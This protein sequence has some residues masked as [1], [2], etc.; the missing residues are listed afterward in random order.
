M[1]R[2]RTGER[3]AEL[4]WHVLA[5][6]L[7]LTGIG[8]TFIWSA[9][10][11]QDSGKM[12]VARQILYVGASLPLMAALIRVPYP[13]FARWAP[14]VYATVSIVLIFLLLRGGGTVRNTASYIRLP[15]GFGLQPSEFAKIAVIMM[16]ATYLRFRPAPDRFRA[17]W[18]PFALVGFP[19]LLV[20]KQPDLGTAVV[21]VPVLFAMLF[22][23][24][25]AAWRII[26]IVGLVAVMGVG[27]YHSPLI[28][29]YQKKRIDNFFVSIPKLTEEVKTLRAAGQHREANE[30]DAQLRSMKQD[31]NLQAYHAQISIG[32]GG[33]FGKGIGK[34]PH[35]QLDFLPERHN[36]FIFAVIGEEW[37][38]VGSTLVLL[39]A[40]LLCALILGVAARTRDGFGRLLCVG[41]ATMFGF[42]TFV[43]TGV[44]TGLLPITGL[45]LPFLSAGGSS[46]MASFF[47]LAIVL[48]VGANKVTAL[49]GETFGHNVF[50]ET[51]PKSRHR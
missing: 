11:A 10:H 9:T 36:D 49:D 28:R 3:L 17:L 44:A 4:D 25:C 21:L 33:T 26:V 19:F 51:S 31:Q 34:G 7:V 38:F 22:A 41:I 16:L 43:N 20:A 40:L 46:L 14:A 8:L 47:A 29:D 13:A 2:R 42:Q 18:G 6:A 12:I 5:V 50:G 48:N 30:I 37:G 35:N 45:T 39:L 15:F 32:S 27:F 1:S 23:A 24:G